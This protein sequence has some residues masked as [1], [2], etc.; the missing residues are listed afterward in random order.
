M[1]LPTTASV[2]SNIHRPLCAALIACGIAAVSGATAY[3][4]GESPWSEDVRSAVRLVSGAN[5]NGDANL[6]AGIEIKPVTLSIY[7][8]NLT[9]S[10]GQT[11][12]G[13]YGGR[14]AGLIDVATI[15]PR[16]IGLTAGV[17]F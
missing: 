12:A 16:T 7:A 10:G 11:Y 14:Y 2:M 8:K 3:A 1:G 17:E 9:N 4:A 6:R 5:K 15:R 13:P